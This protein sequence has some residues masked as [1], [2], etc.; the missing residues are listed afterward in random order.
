MKAMRCVA[1]LLLIGGACRFGGPSGNPSACIQLDDAG[2]A[3]TPCSYDGSSAE[4]EGP[5]D[6]SMDVSAA[7]DAPSGAPAD[8][9]PDVDARGDG[10]EG[11]GGEA[12]ACVPPASVPVCDPVTNTGCTLLQ[13]DV[14]ITQSTPTG[15]CVAGPIIP[16][17]EN[18]PCTQ[19]SGSTPCQPDLSCFG[20]VCRRVCFCDS[21]CMGTECCSDRYATTGFKL[22]DA[23]Q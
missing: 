16:V 14:D 13:C 8:A 5:E 18:A 10:P 15:V 1:P 9:S 11:D 20:G 6:A 21:D 3:Q 4:I 23:C 2:D 22:C 17:A 12:G 7:I 19:A